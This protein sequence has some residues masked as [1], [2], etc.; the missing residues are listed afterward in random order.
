MSRTR[1]CH[2]L[3][4]ALLTGCVSWACSGFGQSAAT[5]ASSSADSSLADPVRELREQ[6]RELQSAVAEIRAESQHY[7]AETAELRKELEAVRSGAKPEERPTAEPAQGTQAAGYPATGGPPSEARGEK[8][9]SEHAASL[10]EQFELLSGKVDDQYQTKVE[11]ASKYRMRLSGI[12]LLNLFSNIGTVDNIDFPSRAYGR[13][14]GASGG[15]IG[16]S[17]RQSQ[18]GL[19]VFG[20]RVA[21]ARTT[22]DLQL[23]LAGGFSRTLNGV[24]YGLLRLR[25][26]TMRLDWDKTSIVAGQDALFFSPSSPTSFATL[27]EPALTYAGNLWAW[28]PQV[29]VE[30]R[31]STGEESNLLVQGGLLDPQSGEPP[32]FSYYRQPQAGEMSR[33]PAYGTRVAWTHS[34][35]GQPLRV[36]AGGYYSRQNYGFGR[37]VDAWAGMTDWDLPLS[38]QLSLSGKFYRGR[39]LG[40]LGGGI[41]RSVLFSGDPSSP[42]TEVRALNSVGGWAQLKY[43]PA[44]KVEFNG[45]FGQDIPYSADMR[46]FPAPQAFGDPTLIKNQEGFVNVIYRPRSDLLFSAEYRHLKTYTI[47][48]GN[49]QAHHLNLTMGVLF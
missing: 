46:A 42:L 4:L 21:G 18:V 37:I 10:E 41:G 40:G 29:R 15:S 34:I 1:A 49:Y 47:N 3:R 28:V 44:N 7:R 2:I 16:A 48:N 19:E 6:I 12:V 33:Q 24:N 45:T 39:G 9:K 38:H 36:G 31:W 32:V 8:R 30:H 13:P 17:L 43:R 27:A 23:D 26:G 22:A 35:F 20:P 5:P 25:T 14:P 11:S